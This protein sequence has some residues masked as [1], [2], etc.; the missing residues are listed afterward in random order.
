LTGYRPINT[1]IKAYIKIR[2]EADPVLLADNEWIEMEK[3]EGASIFSSSS[4]LDDFREF[5]FEIPESNKIDGVVA[6]SNETGDY[7]GYRSFALRID[8]LSNNVANVPKV[9]DYR[10]IAFE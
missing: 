10:G 3:I 7:V 6:Y 5:V 4:N 9:L 8:L 2:N 1:D